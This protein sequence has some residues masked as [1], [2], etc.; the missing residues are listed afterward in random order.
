MPRLPSIVFLDMPEERAVRFAQDFTSA[1]CA[2]GTR[3][4]ADYAVIL[5]G[6]P[7]PDSIRDDLAIILIVESPRELS[8][9]ERHLAHGADGILTLPL[10]RQ[11]IEAQLLLARQNRRLKK[12]RDQKID[13]LESSL[14]HRRHIERAVETIV[15]RENV[16][17][18]QAFESL[19]RSAMD[20]RLPIWVHA[21]NLLANLQ[22]VDDKSVG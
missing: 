5:A 20:L 10:R 8:S 6:T 14:R 15:R 1:Q 16:D 3:E 17:R 7:S 13:R 9:V 12:I 4:T 18:I 19:R 11:D 2:I 21:E 22:S